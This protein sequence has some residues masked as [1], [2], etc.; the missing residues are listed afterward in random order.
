MIDEPKKELNLVDTTDCLEAIGVFKCWK[1]LLFVGLLVG[2]V[3]LQVC[4]WLLNSGYVKAGATEGQAVVIEKGKAQE[5]AVTMTVAVVEEVKTEP[6]QIQQAA[7][8]VA[9]DANSVA[10]AEKVAPTNKEV[11]IYLRIKID[12]SHLASAIRFLNFVII[13]AAILYSLTMIFILKVSLIGRLGGINH[14]A[15]AFFISMVLA[16]I[17]VPWQ[18][19]TGGF[20]CGVLYRPSELLEAYNKVPGMDNLAKG[21]YYARFVGYWAIALLMLMAAHLR[22]RKWAGKTLRRL[23]VL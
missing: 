7:I 21:F 12:Y 5:N 23:G 4:F 15:R 19:L 22:S 17:L 1:N 11:P 8:A 3:L 6:N 16:V 9:G 10:A 18:N 13:P 20:F 2:L 14:I